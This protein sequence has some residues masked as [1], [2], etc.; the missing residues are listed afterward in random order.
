MGKRDH[1]IVTV[2][3]EL[4]A[5]KYADGEQMPGVYELNQRFGVSTQTSVKAM[6]MLDA[7]GVL[8]ARHGVGY[9]AV[10]TDAPVSALQ[11]YEAAHLALT[12][13]QDAIAVALS[14][15]E[16]MKE[17]LEREEAAQ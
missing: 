9:F 4:R 17:S 3:D 5:G 8:E 16:A 14:R 11:H 10:V 2:R 15:L 6:Q 12:G 7:E 13:A 1:I